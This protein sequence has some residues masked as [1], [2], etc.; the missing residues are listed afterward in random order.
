MA[1]RRQWTPENM[2]SAFEDVTER[3]I[4]IS[5]AARIHCVPRTTLSD[6]VRGKQEL[7]CAIG[8]PPAIADEE[9]I[10]R[11]C[12]YLAEH[13][14]PV[15]RGQVI[16]LAW[17]VS[18][19]ENQDA[20]GGGGPSLKW[21]RGFRKR[22]PELTLRKP[23]Y[24]DR[25]RFGNA[26]DDI[27]NDYFT[28]LEKTLKSNGLL[29]KPHLIFNCDEAAVNL[30]RST[31]RVLVPIKTKHCH[32]LALASNQHISV[33]CAISASGSTIPPLLIFSKAYPT[34]RKVKTRCLYH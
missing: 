16:A 4:S 26:T 28:T 21:W 10:V 12:V 8:R 20:F 30:N 27:I 23:E 9:A 14:Y 33:L 1:K 19:R 11:Y 34:S 29:D 31:Q 32:S 6:R 15:T 2:R 5:E 13:R 18:L 22:H 17:A 7:S 3:G 24:I 25:G